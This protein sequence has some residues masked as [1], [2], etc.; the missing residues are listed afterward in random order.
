LASEDK[1]KIME[2]LVEKVTI[3]SSE[4]DITFSLAP[5]LKKYAKTNRS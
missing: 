5:L 4:I 3:G 1:R 2:A